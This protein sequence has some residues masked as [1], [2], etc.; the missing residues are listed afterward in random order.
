MLETSLDVKVMAPKIISPTFDPLG[1]LKDQQLL[2]EMIV[3]YAKSTNYAHRFI[4]LVYER[5]ENAAK[6]KIWKSLDS[7]KTFRDL[8]LEIA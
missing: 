2:D 4:A 7:N 5:L 3:N 1:I 8:A 6:M